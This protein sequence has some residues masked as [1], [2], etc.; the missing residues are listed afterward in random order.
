MH[1]DRQLSAAGRFVKF[2][3]GGTVS[4]VAKG[5][6]G[7]FHHGASVSTNLPRVRVP[8]RLVFFLDADTRSISFMA[9]PGLFP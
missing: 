3:V 2:R 1:R 5:G 8:R 9:T 4:Q 7:V 6:G